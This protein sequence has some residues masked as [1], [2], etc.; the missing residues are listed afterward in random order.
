MK[1]NESFTK[2]VHAAISTIPVGSIVTY[3][4]IAAYIGTRAYRAV[5]SACNKS[6]G[7]PHVPCHRVVSSSFMLHGFASGIENK[8]LLLER[9]GIMVEEKVI[10]GR[11]DYAIVDHNRHRH[12][13]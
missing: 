2:R 4:D 11:R 6:P 3:K 12:I 10:K 5:G 1:T 13:L 7:M 8:R 9:E